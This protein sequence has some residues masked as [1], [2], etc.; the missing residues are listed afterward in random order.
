MRWSS[1]PVLL[2]AACLSLVAA[3]GG[4]DAPV[5]KMLGSRKFL[6]DLK[7]RGLPFERTAHADRAPSSVDAEERPAKRQVGGDDGQC[8]AGYGS[9]AKGY[10]CSPEGY[11]LD[12]DP[13]LWGQCGSCI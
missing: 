1:G 5:P 10:C 4:H 11:V 7:A 3:H 13:S 9:C 2:V 6:A 12:Y 8:G